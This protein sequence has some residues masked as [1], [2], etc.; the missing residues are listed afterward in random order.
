MP[1][2][3]KT[4]PTMT[5]AQNRGPNVLYL[6]KNLSSAN[7]QL[8]SYREDC[9]RMHFGGQYE[10]MVDL[11]GCFHDNRKLTNIHSPILVGTG[12]RHDENP[13][14]RKAANYHELSRC[15]LSIRIVG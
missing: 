11:R 12:G 2:G 1:T 15:R 6:S 3:S 9:S 10:N 5:P 14:R 7:Q 8:S 13:D 4:K